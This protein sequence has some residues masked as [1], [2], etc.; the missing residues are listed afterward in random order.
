MVQQASATHQP[1][2]PVQSATVLPTTVHPTTVLAA[3]GNPAT[4]NPATGHQVLVDYT[5]VEENP[6][7]AKAE[8]LNDFDIVTIAELL[9]FEKSSTHNE[10]HTAVAK[11]E[12]TKT[13]AIE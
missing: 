4:G 2:L 9:K 10:R 7:P 13:F 12:F 8:N 11:C 6:S 1:A 3:T 5:T